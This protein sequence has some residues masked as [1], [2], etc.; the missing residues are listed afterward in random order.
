MTARI[1]AFDDDAGPAG[2]L[3][4]AMRLGLARIDLHRFPDGESLPTVRDTADHAIVYRSLDRPDDKLMPL[5]L[6]VDALRRAGARRISLVA[7]YMPYLRQDTVFAP[8]QPLSRDVIGALLGEQIDDLTTVDPH[9]HRTHDLSPVFAGKP[10]RVLSAVPAM[11]KALGPAPDTIVLG[12]D[13]ESA[14]WARTLAS[15]LGAPFQTLAKTRS[16]DRL[17]DLALPDPPLFAGRRVILIDDICSSGATLLLALRRLAEAGAAR[18]DLAVVHALF[19]AIT[20]TRLLAAGAARIV[21]SDSC[22]HPTNQVAL[23]PLLAAAWP[24]LTPDGADRP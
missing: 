21:S 20:E 8:G 7:P 17:V 11:A 5:L 18:V 4:E 24:S 9:L 10:V 1:H 23:A 19:D 6:A 22:R 13:S 2:R 12:P 3:A 15:A 16:G 14:P